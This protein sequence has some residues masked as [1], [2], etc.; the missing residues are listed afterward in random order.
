MSFPRRSPDV[1][2][3]GLVAT[4]AGRPVALALMTGFLLVGMNCGTA[5]VG[6]IHYRLLWD[7]SRIMASPNTGTN[8]TTNA[9]PIAGPSVGW[10]VIT[11]LGYEV[12]V[13]RGWLVSS[14]LTLVPCGD[15]V[16]WAGAGNF[17]VGTA[18][19]GHSGEVDLSGITS[20]IVESLTEPAVVEWRSSKIP[21]TRYCQLHYLLA[22]S[23]ERAVAD[24]AQV[25][26][27]GFTLWIDAA[28]RAPG[29]ARE[30]PLSVRI[31]SAHGGLSGLGQVRLASRVAVGMRTETLPERHR[32]WRIAARAWQDPLDPSFASRLGGRWNRPNS[33]LTLCLN[34]DALTACINLR[35]FI[36]DWPYEPEDLRDGQG[37]VLVG[38]TL[39]RSQTVADVHTARGIAAVGLPASYPEN[40]RGELVPQPICQAIGEQAKQ[41]DL[42]GVRCRSARAPNGAGRELAWF[43]ATVRSR[44]RQVDTLLFEK[45]FWA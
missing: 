43:P 13:D 3:A 36:A 15:D 12:R 21:S 29:S 40:D 28:Y 18:Y 41:R 25:D 7:E 2:A 44:A 39:P 27:R 26:M 10:S 20:P 4:T 22:R 38:A 32:W 11:D 23:D 45:W 34:E 30:H 8:T 19:A 5:P 1:S 6:T 37:P 9:G 14:G 16:G 42:R 17:G 24:A 35:L 33:F 31:A